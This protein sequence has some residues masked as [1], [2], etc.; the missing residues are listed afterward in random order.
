M[1]KLNIIFNIPPSPLHLYSSHSNPSC[2]IPFFIP[3]L[4]S[5]LYPSSYLLY[6][7]PSSIIIPLLLPSLYPSPFLLYIPLS[8]FIIP[9]L[10]PYLYPFFFLLYTPPPSFYR[11]LLL[12]SVY[13]SSFF[14]YPPPPSFFIPFLLSSLHPSFFLHYTPPSSFYFIFT[15]TLYL[16]FPAFS[17]L[18]RIFP[19]IFNDSHSPPSSLFPLLFSSPPLNPPWLL[20]MF[21]PWNQVQIHLIILLSLSLFSLSS[22]G[23]F[24]N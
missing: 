17:Y 11:P 14:L 24:I 3:L 4:L 19:L 12:P 22:M 9:L 18:A 13:P 10:L 1:I 15:I 16:Q 20:I 23:I 8:S 2:N 5:S 7:P 21:Y 6:I